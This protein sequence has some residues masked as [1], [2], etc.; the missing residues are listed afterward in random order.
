MPLV[1]I[2]MQERSIDVKRTIVKKVTEAFADIIHM[3][4]EK[5]TIIFID[6]IECPPA[7]KT[8]EITGDEIITV[9]IE[10][11]E[12]RTDETKEEIVNAFK[13]ELSK[14][15][16]VKKEQINVIFKDMH[17]YNHGRGGILT[18]DRWTELGYK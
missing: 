5:I 12:G 11:F 10:M 3:D 1:H 4:W 8:L 14:L 9:C 15:I 7:E 17:R 16:S 18:L 13:T 6:A 2:E